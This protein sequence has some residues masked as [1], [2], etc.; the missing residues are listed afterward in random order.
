[1]DPLLSAQLAFGY[2]FTAEKWTKASAPR[3]TARHGLS[4]ASLARWASPCTTAWQGGGE[5]FAQ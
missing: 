3:R 4:D 2:G 5:P 1:M